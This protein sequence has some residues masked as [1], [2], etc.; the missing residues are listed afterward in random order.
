MQAKNR[1]SSMNLFSLFSKEWPGESETL[2]K[3]QRVK[4]MDTLKETVNLKGN[5]NDL[6]HFFKCG[7]VVTVA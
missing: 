5:P 1:K 4:T 3:P 6:S 2:T 7:H